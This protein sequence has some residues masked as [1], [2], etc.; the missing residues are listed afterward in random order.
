[1]M[2]TDDTSATAQQM[3]LPGEGDVPAAV[4]IEPVLSLG[5]LTQVWTL[6]FGSDRTLGATE[7]V[8]WR[9]RWFRRLCKQVLE[10][11]VWASGISRETSGRVCKHGSA[12]LVG[13]AGGTRKG[14][15]QGCRD[16]FAGSG[17]RHGS[18]LYP[19]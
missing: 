12:D 14:R 6:G 16:C 1:M 18:E 2:Y 15:S 3:P 17:G 7:G 4:T 13:D 19:T 9:I 10:L 8:E 11:A 5:E